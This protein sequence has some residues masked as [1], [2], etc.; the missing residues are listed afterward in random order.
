MERRSFWTAMGIL[1]AVIMV[2]AGAIIRMDRQGP[3]WDVSYP[4]ADARIEWSGAGYNGIY[5]GK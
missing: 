5:G 3:A 4:M 1:A 2:L